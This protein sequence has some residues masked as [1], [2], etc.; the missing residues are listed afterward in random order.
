MSYRE[1]DIAQLLTYILSY[2]NNLK[3]PLMVEKI[4]C[5]AND[6]FSKIPIY[7]GII[8]ASLG[9]VFQENLEPDKIGIGSKVVSQVGDETVLGTVSGIE[10]NSFYLENV[11]IFKTVSEIEIS[12]DTI[13]YQINESVLEEDWPSLIFTKE[14]K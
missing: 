8:K 12:K 14:V 6:F 9:K 5:K 1:T 11:K 10:D 7:P 2:C 3:N 13:T 4:I